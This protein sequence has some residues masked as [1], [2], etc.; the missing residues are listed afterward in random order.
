MAPRSSYIT[1]TDQFC[2]AGGSSQGVRKVSQ[3]FGGGLEVKLALNHWKLA[4]ETH[5]TNFPDTMHDCTDVSA[6]DPRRY[7]STDI[8]ITSPECTNHSNAQGKKKAKKQLELFEKG[9]IDPAADRSRATMWDVVRFAEVH[10]YNI[11]ITENVVEA[12][13]WIMFDS[14]IHAMRTLGYEHKCCFF[15]S[16]HFWPTPQSRDR[17]YVVFWKKGNRVPDLTHTPLANCYSC[18]KDVNAVQS[19][20]RSQKSYKY[21]TGYVYCCPKCASI[22][23]PYYYAAFNCIDWSQPGTRIGDRNKPLAEKTKHRIEYGLRKYGTAPFIFP[24]VY[25]DEARGVVKNVLHRF[26]P[27][28]SFGIDGL[29]THP[30]II[31]SEHSQ[32]PPNSYVKSSLAPLSTQ[33]TRQT[34][35]VVTPIIAP[36]IVNN[37]GQ[38]TA[39]SSLDS[40]TTQTTVVSN[41]ILSK[42]PFNSFLSYYYGNGF[43]AS[44]ISEAMDT[45]TCNDRAG[46]TNVHEGAQYEDCYYRTLK[47]HEVKAGMAFDDDYVILGSAKEQVYQSGNAVTPPVMEFLVERSI[48]SL[49]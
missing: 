49:S 7:P 40:L 26:H 27:Q 12:R 28:P 20:K 31:T 8:L 39:T 9:I 15:N 46:I 32:Q 44:H 6:C 23:E 48:M 13:K 16:M 35:A 2:G 11:I 29:I 4:I 36:I 5:S 22:V 14:W 24:T 34:F 18:G 25:H 10:S 17:M 3:R 1:V 42:Q 41:G 30:F 33:A 37:K 19:W 38:S 43:Q 45:I 47:A 21:R